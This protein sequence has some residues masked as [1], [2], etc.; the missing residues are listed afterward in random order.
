MSE[1]LGRAS[2]A[3]ILVVEDDAHIAVGLKFNLEQEG[4]EVEIVGDGRQAVERLA[5]SDPPLQLVVF[6][7]TT[8]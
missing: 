5:R 1:R 7:Q 4:H 2:S 3:C 6:P 8:R